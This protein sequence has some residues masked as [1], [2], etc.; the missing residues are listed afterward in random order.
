MQDIS[1]FRDFWVPS[2]EEENAN[3][4]S[5]PGK[6]RRE[7]QLNMQNIPPLL[8]YEGQTPQP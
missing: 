3:K 5:V 2:K 8:D 4:T 1:P 7:K 6:T